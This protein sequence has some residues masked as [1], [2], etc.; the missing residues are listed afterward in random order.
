MR[1]VL[2]TPV[3]SDLEAMGVNMMDPAR[4]T[5]V[6][7]SARQTAA[8]QLRAQ[9]AAQVDQAWPVAKGSSI[10]DGA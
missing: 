7:D 5:D 2:L 4:R 1:V 3:A 6:L 9:V 10:G 8:A